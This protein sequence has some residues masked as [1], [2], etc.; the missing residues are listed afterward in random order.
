[1][2]VVLLGPDYRVRAGCTPCTVLHLHMVQFTVGR[3]L[4]ASQKGS[5]APRHKIAWR[6]VLSSRGL[7]KKSNVE[8]GMVTEARF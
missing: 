8:T 1:M 2:L 5:K 3:W 6:S 7:K 4:Q